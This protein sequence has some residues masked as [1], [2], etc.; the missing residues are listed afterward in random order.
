MLVV[1]GD[2]E[3]GKNIIDDKSVLER[4]TYD[5]YETVKLLL[6]W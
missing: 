5:Y 6:L 4:Q 2:K 3:H 1:T